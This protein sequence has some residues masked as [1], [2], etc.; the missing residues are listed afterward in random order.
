MSSVLITGAAGFIGSHLVKR[1]L[2]DGHS[3]IG[4][5]NFLT[6][7]KEN[8]S[9][10]LEKPN[11]S[12]IEQDVSVPHDVS[13]YG[14]T[15]I[16]LIFHLA[17]PASPNKNSPKS[18]IAYPIETLLVN[19]IGTYHML[20]VAKEHGSS[21]LYTSSSEIYGDPAESPQKETYF[22]NVN[23]T[24][25][26]S[27][28]D[29]GKRFG[30]AMVMGFVRKHGLNARIIRIFNTYGPYMQKDDGRVVSNFINQ[31]LVGQNMTIYGDGSQT[32]S[33][34]YVDDMVEGLIRAMFTEGSKGEVF[35]LGNPD[36]RTI[37]ELAELVK[38]LTQ[39][40]SD[41]V[42][43]DLPEDDPKRRCPDITKAQTMLGWGPKIGVEQG[44]EKTI[45]Y[46]KTV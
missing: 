16:D 24:G 33:F 13:L 5:D 11:F 18:Y 23:P 43:Q 4:V 14:S 6:G 15:K 7:S 45:R 46:F 36:E 9:E 8:L 17:S 25:I 22:G 12:F 27:V 44:L 3:V 42:N 37:R 32:R 20:L 10:L 30:E 31:A 2:S 1:L 19:S 26:R 39:S 35:N 34:C 38:K 21:V 28:Y 41:I 29:E 40:S